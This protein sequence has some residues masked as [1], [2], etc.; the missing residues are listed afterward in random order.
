MFAACRSAGKSFRACMGFP[1]WSYIIHMT[2]LMA[3]M[4]PIS[5]SDEKVGLVTDVA[6]S[7]DSQ[8]GAWTCRCRASMTKIALLSRP[9]E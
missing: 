6:G 4:S 7:N 8:L 3:K 9:D 1:W 2:V 5:K